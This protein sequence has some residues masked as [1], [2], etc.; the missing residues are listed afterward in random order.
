PPPRPPPVGRGGGGVGG[1]ARGGVVAQGGGVGGP[2]PP[3]PPPRRGGGGAGGGGGRA[4]GAGGRIATGWPPPQ[5]SPASGGG[6]IGGAAHRSTFGQV[7]R[8]VAALSHEWRRRPRT[9]PALAY[10]PGHAARLAHRVQPQRRRRRI[11]QMTAVAQREAQTLAAVGR[12]LQAPQRARI[13]LLRPAQHGGAGTAAQALL[14]RPQ[15]I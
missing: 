9:A 10:L 7:R 14:E 12:H 1:A 6:S 15:R 3:P 13:C 2:P 5:P 8:N 4:G 11:G